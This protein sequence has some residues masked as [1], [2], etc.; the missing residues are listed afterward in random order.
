MGRGCMMILL[1]IGAIAAAW[2]AYVYFHTRPNSFNYRMTVE[3]ETPEG[4]RSGSGVIEVGAANRVKFLPEGGVRSVYVRGQAVI[5]EMPTGGPIF[6]LMKYEEGGLVPLWMAL[7]TLVPDFNPMDMVKAAG[8][9]R[10]GQKGVVQRKNYP[11]LVRFTDIEDPKTVEQIDPG[12]LGASFGEGYMLKSITIEITDDPVTTGID[13]RLE[14]IGIRPGHSLDND[15][16]ATTNPTL[17]Q[18]L[19]H[20]DFIKGTIK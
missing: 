17:G 18:R 8:R 5:I 11:M 14:A 2:A 15:F 1:G 4:V 3:I 16:Q 6:A 7:R 10:L 9:M 20:K 19:G 12:D 13:E